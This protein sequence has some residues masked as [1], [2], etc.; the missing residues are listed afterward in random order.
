MRTQGLFDF[1]FARERQRIKRVARADDQ[2]LPAVQYPGR[3]PVAYGVRQ[4]LAPD[5]LACGGIE[6]DQV[7]RI[8]RE[9]KITRGRQYAAAHAAA[10]EAA[11]RMYVFPF[12]RSCA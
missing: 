11:S 5:R 8:A 7:A 10:A 1:V 9:Q 2:V 6:G 12:H 3:R 4:S